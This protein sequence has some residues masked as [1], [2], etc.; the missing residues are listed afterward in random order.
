MPEQTKKNSKVGLIVI[1]AI[2]AL[3]IA[4]GIIFGGKGENKSDLAACGDFPK[5]AH[6]S[7]MA[8]YSD[9]CRNADSG[10]CYYKKM[11][12]QLIPGCDPAFS[13]E[14]P[15]GKPECFKMVSDIYDVKG[16]QTQKGQET[17]R[18]TDNCAGTSEQ[19]VDSKL[20]DN[21]KDLSACGAFPVVPEGGQ[22]G[23]THYYVCRDISTGACYYK[24]DYSQQ[25]AGCDP[26][27]SDAN[28]YGN[29][30][31]FEGFS[32]IYGADG[33]SLFKA[34]AGYYAEHPNDVCGNTSQEYFETK[35]TK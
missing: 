7:G 8:S 23:A 3:F 22:P 5:V 24:K 16:T 32:D 1:L 12:A 21:W 9:V 13:N 35:T 28:P 25:K 14:N 27:F 34:F 31:C 10:E 17:Y 29:A 15:S 4:L 6:P 20:K 11:H 2:F 33:K 18:P 30:E 26:K 19:Y